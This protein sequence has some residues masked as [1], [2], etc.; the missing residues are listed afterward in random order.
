MFDR[1]VIHDDYTLK[2]RQEG[3]GSL[4]SVSCHTQPREPV[5]ALPL[6]SSSIVLSSDAPVWRSPTI[7][8]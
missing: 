6:S 3:L 8:P 2:Q 4:G 5:T 7:L 1:I